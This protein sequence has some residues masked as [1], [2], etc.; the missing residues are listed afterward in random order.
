MTPTAPSSEGEAA[1]PVA[2]RRVVV[3][4]NPA[5]G[6]R[7]SARLQAGLAALAA[8]GVEVDLRE[9]AGAGDALRIARQAAAPAAR[10]AARVDAVVAA[11]G[12][13]TV[14]EVVNGLFAAAV[15]DGAPAGG[16]PGAAARIP[17]LG[18]FALGTANVLAREVGLPAGL[19]AQ[20]RVIAHGP[21]ARVHVGA[22][23]APGGGAVR[24]FTVM[25]SAGFDARVVDGVSL[26]LKRRIGSMAYAVAALRE[27]LRGPRAPLDLAID[28]RT[29]RAHGA[30]VANGRHY[31]V[32]FDCAPRASLVRG[33]FEVVLLE[34]GGRLAVLRQALG[35][36]RGRIAEID[37]VSVESA[38]EVAIRG[39]AG[40]A[41]Q[42]DGDVVARVPA[43]LAVAA[44]LLPIA[45]PADSPLRAGGGADYNPERTEGAR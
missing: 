5:A 29:V 45:V 19:A 7:R 24:I 39:P 12:D 35:L 28:G 9:T 34:K 13:G 3:I 23:H 44:A 15:P 33:G 22:V 41:I 42:A 11:G 20:A 40:A 6:P 30:I 26:A 32:G 36:V 10:G 18:L 16:G 21:L 27:L 4:H 38:S 2:R 14:N 31:G 1:A 17:P 37:G 25:A 43:T 8:E